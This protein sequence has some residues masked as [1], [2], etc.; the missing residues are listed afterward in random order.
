MGNGNRSRPL[1]GLRGLAAVAVIFYHSILA[2]G[3]APLALLD[4]PVQS[5]GTTRSILTKIVLT[6]LNGNTAVLLFFVLSGF[7]L[8]LSLQRE[9]GTTREICVRFLVRR[10]CRLFP[11][12]IF[13]MALCYAVASLYLQLGLPASIHLRAAANPYLVLQNAFLMKITMHGASWTIQA[14]MLAVPFILATF[15]L[16][17]ALGLVGLAISLAFS[18]IALE[19]P[20]AVFGSTVISGTIYAF[21][22]GMI[23]G[24]KNLRVAFSGMQPSAIAVLVAAFF[25]CRLFVPMHSTMATLAE[26]AL[27]AAIVGS[28]YANSDGSVIRL[29]NKPFAQYLGKVSFSL[30]LLNVPVMWLVLVVL[31]SYGAKAPLEIGLIAGILTTLISLPLAAFGEKYFEQGGANLGR[32]LTKPRRQMVLAPAE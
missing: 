6:A 19:N 12:V 1:D 20:G 7:V 25:L 17:R 16:Q 29:L 31:D 23:V 2:M 28:V 18:L 24:D 10:V 3:P 9:T 14:E 4:P 22:A 27:A 5:F 30:Y 13:C 26:V 15:F 11:A 32:Q 8:S 21:C